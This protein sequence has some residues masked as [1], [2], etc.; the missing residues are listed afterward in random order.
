[1][2]S[3]AAGTQLVTMIAGAITEAGLWQ[4]AVLMTDLKT[5]YLVQASPRVMFHAQ[6][7]GSVI[8]C[9]VGSAI[10]RFF[11]AVY[12]IPRK[13]F[14]LPLAHMWINTARLANG[15]DL[16]KGIVPFALAAFSIS[17]CLRVICLAAG[18][19]R[20]AIWLPSGVAI[21]IGKV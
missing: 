9:F 19:R 11:T 15:N 20:W 4:S 16:P 3:K 21:S 8:G 5:A 13:D 14:S 18:K 7:L 10:Y 1:M 17:A 2:V 6:P 12:S